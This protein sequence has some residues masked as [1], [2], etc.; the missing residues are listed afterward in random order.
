MEHINLPPAAELISWYAAHV[1]DMIAENIAI[2]QVPAPSWDEHDRALFLE[3]RFQK[4]GLVDV[5]IDAADNVI[6][7]LPGEA[8][9]P[10]LLLAAHHDT[11]FP[12][13]TD[14]TVRREGSKLFAPGVRD[15]SFGVTSLIWLIEGL[16]QL[17][18][19]LP[20]TLIC[21]A[22]SGEEG[23]GDLKG[24]KAAMAR[25]HEVA[26][27]VIAVDGGLGGLTTG[28][29]TS[30]RHRVTVKAAGGHSYG[31]F[32]ASSAVHSLGRMIAAIADLKVPTSPKTTYNVGVITGGN[33]VNSIAATAD[34][35]IDMRSEQREALMALEG[36]L[37]AAIESVRAA[38]QVEVIDELLGDRPGGITPEDHPFVQMILGIQ[39][40]LGLPINTHSSSTDANV[41]MGY[42][43]PAVCFGCGLG[44]N[45]HR[46][47]EWLDTTN[48]EIGL[49]QL[50]QVVVETMK[51]PKRA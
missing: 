21:V 16:K 8:E 20:G 11:V 28:G 43:I 38:D 37:F 10:T 42:G 5:E 17:D 24:M 3:K 14:L 19:K 7:F 27:Y 15:N 9:G 46:L 48:C 6:G 35:L 33:S 2:T 4:L 50:V 30:R 18:I 39:K 29:V 13:E 45:A 25:F 40:E 23:L 41:A 31:A 49:T 32:G 12:R 34:M 22:T 1:E 26:D 36:E 47:D 44:G 51:M